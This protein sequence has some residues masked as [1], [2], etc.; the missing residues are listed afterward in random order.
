VQKTKKR[1]TTPAFIDK[2]IMV[3]IFLF[4]TTFVFSKWL[5]IQMRLLKILRQKVIKF[6]INRRGKY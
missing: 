5:D 2:K 4:L 3:A 6:H 1:I